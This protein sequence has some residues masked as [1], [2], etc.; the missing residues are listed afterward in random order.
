MTQVV[1]RLLDAGRTATFLV[2]DRSDLELADRL[3]RRVRDARP[4]V[5]DALATCRASDLAGL[6]AE[7]ASAE[8]VVASRFHNVICALKARRPVVSL[9]YAGKNADL[10]ERFGLAGLD[11]PI[12]AFDV[13]RLL[14][15]VDRLA[16]T[17]DAV[18]KGIDAMLVE[19]ERD[20]GEHLSAVSSALL[21]SGPRAG[22]SP[23]LSS[24]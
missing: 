9:G 10:L 1:V 4:L 7:M 6:M 21:G 16:G 12:D 5:G 19:V 2:G 11:Q 14:A 8:V 15:D 24:A 20:V 22:T 18:T 3:E 13:D 23:S 17:Q